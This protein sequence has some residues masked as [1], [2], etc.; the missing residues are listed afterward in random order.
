MTF[1]KIDKQKEKDN[2]KKWKKV[3][4]KKVLFSNNTL[5][6]TDDEDNSI[7]LSSTQSSDLKLK[8]KNNTDKTDN[9]NVSK[10]SVNTRL[11]KIK[12]NKQL[13]IPDNNNLI[14]LSD[15]K[16][17]LEKNTII[18]E[19]LLT[20]D[21]ILDL[22]PVLKKDKLS[23]INNVFGKNEIKKKSH[24]LEKIDI[25]NK[26]IYKDAFGN[27]MDENVNLV[28]FWI[29]SKN[30]NNQSNQPDQLNQ[31]SQTNQQNNTSSDN[32]KF[33]FFDQTKKIKNKININKKKL[34]NT[35]F[36]KK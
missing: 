16:K 28:G 4:Q 35:N 26:S 8:N 9:K 11:K 27:L 3:T 14:N 7:I 30:L 22:Y 20:I 23:I 29:E 34:L 13:E 25:P 24:V 12:K 10:Q 6:F 21:K 17:L 5:S 19:R 18:K 36:N 1:I 32:I 2:K 31:L 15:N 33:I